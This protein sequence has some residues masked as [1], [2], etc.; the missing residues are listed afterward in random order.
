MRSWVADASTWTPECGALSAEDGLGALSRFSRTCAAVV[1]RIR[2]PD[3][4]V[5]VVLG[6]STQPQAAPAD[7]ATEL[8]GRWRDCGVDLVIA[9]PDTLPLSGLDA[10]VAA[11]GPRTVLWAVVDLQPGAELA[12]VV[13][14]SR[15]ATDKRLEI[16]WTDDVGPPLPNHL[17]SCTG[18]LSLLDTVGPQSVSIK[19]GSWSLAVTPEL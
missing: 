17:N 16:E 7:I 14:L 18:V 15:T 5:L 3:A 1:E 11:A 8:R 6:T 12:A 10:L 19:V 4:D 9:G 2:I 13:E